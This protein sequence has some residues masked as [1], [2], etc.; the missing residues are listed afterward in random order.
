MPHTKEEVLAAIAQLG[1]VAAAAK[2][3]NITRQAISRRFKR[4]PENDPLRRRY[5][6]LAGLSKPGPEPEW[7]DQKARIR[8]NV[9]AYRERQKKFKESEENG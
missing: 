6:A 2:E 3:L 9:R 8:H 5:E 4:L 1:S 7:D